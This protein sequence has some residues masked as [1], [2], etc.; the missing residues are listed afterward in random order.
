MLTSTVRLAGVVC[1]PMAVL[2]GG[3]FHWCAALAYIKIGKL[4][5]V[6]TSTN[7]AGVLEV[8]VDARELAL[9]RQLKVRC[10]WVGYIPNVTTHGTA[11]WLLLELQDRV[12]DCNLQGQLVRY[13][14]VL[15][16]RPVL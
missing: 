8:E 15:S 9:R 14:T 11:L 16:H 1:I 2:N 12:C 10:V 4:A 5:I 6:L 13:H 3:H 7:K